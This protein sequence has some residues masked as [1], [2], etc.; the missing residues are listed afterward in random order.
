MEPREGQD[1]DTRKG[2]FRWF[3][4]AMF[5][6]IS[7]CLLCSYLYWGLMQKFAGLTP[8]LAEGSRD[9]AIYRRAG[10]AILA[11][12]VPY[13]DFFIEYPPGSL[14]AFVPPAL[15]TG[16]KEA[17]ASLFASEMALVLVA[18][19]ALT[20]YAARSLGRPWLLSAVVFAAAAILLYPVAVTRYDAIVALSFAAAVALACGP[21][22]SKRTADAT[23]SSVALV[24]AWAS[25]G[26]G[27]A[28]KLVPALAT[29]PLALFAGR[30][31]RTFGGVARG[32]VIF[33][34]VVAAFFLPA[35]LF[36]G[37]G[38][39]ESFTYHADRGLQVESLASSV[40]M[41]LGYV[42]GTTFEF[43]AVDVRGRGV[44]LL[45]SLS[46]PVTA[47]L[48]IVTGAAAYREHRGGKLGP[49]QLPRFAAAFV[50]AFLISSKVL[51]P[52]YVIWLL[53]LVPLSTGGVWSLGISAVFLSVC[54][55]TTQVYPY[56]YLEVMNSRPPGTDILLGRNLLL[57]VLWG[58]ML[59]LPYED[60]K[61]E[62][63]DQTAEQTGAS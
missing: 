22:G 3:S 8:R 43:G 12:E 61:E 19:L 30:D 53:P 63:A 57:V 34:G 16:S 21:A 47:L 4:G 37:G 6:W 44:E 17:Y 51:S 5:F 45:S 24:A 62:S 42:N 54:W 40:L 41:R 39:I 58:L 10:E 48:L 9:V 52:Q 27:A 28:A 20:A 59:S 18:A 25:L 26:F 33:L 56:H 38:F 55:M 1:R 35:I 36:G 46:L 2:P 32:A 14:P 11:G 31:G 29:L 15:F 13:R 50:L 7:V 49:G 60:E 23:A